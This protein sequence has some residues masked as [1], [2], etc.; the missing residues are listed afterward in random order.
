MKTNLPLIFYADDDAAFLQLFQL[1]NGE[2]GPTYQ[3]KCF[4]SGDDLIESMSKL[5]Q[6]FSLLPHL[7][8]LDLHMP[9]KDGIEVLQELKAHSDFKHI[10][11]VII[12]DSEDPV[13]QKLVLELGAE[14]FIP[15]PMAYSGITDIISQIDAHLPKEGVKQAEKE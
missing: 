6:Q 9:A 13:K 10:P 11:V 5:N 2:H 7:I 8:L 14:E 4:A 15:K 1:N 12:S 3:I